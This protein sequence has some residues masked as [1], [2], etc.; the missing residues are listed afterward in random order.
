LLELEAELDMKYCLLGYCDSVSID[1]ASYSTYMWTP[2]PEP[3]YTEDPGY[4]GYRYILDGFLSANFPGTYI[5]EASTPSLVEVVDAVAGGQYAGFSDGVVK[6]EGYLSSA[7]PGENMGKHTS[8]EEVRM[9][10]ASGGEWY[11]GAKCDQQKVIHAAVGFNDASSHRYFN[12][13][14]V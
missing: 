6:I 14:C 4:V 13:I 11:L 5:K 9:I 8:V 1:I 3:D 7:W 12:W 10:S 2:K